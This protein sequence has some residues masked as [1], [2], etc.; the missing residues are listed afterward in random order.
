MSKQR[1]ASRLVG[2]LLMT[3]TS[4]WLGVLGCSEDTGVVEGF[5]GGSAGN[6]QGKAGSL[7]AGTASSGAPAAGGVASAGRGAGGGSSASSGNGAGGSSGGGAGGGTGGGGKAAAGGAGRAGSSASSGGRLGSSGSSGAAGDSGGAPDNGGAPSTGGGCAGRDLII[8]EDFEDTDVGDVPDGWERH[9]SLIAVNDDDARGGSRSLKI[10]PAA[11][12]ERRI[13]HDASLLGAQHW[14]RIHY[15]VQTPTPDAFV[16][17][18]MVSLLGDGPENGLSDYRP[19]DTIKQNIET[20]DVG[21]RHNFI[22]NVQIIGKS[23]FGTET[24]YDYTFDEEWHCAEYHIQAS[25]QSYVLYLDGEDILSF[26]NGAGNYDDSDIPNVFDE[27]RVGWIEYQNDPP[28]F[29][30]WIDDIAFDDERIG[31]EP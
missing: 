21:G 16:H 12:E 26:E 29:T 9:G 8:C 18:T 6:S 15:K 28:G 3:G 23:E 1:A 22:Y 25:N 13:Y 30:A 4:I 2:S 24:G 10:S 11:Q 31:C 27:L 17:A 7:G 14:G 20:P 19:I 5:V